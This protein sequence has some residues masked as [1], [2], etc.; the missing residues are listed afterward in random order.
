VVR[1]EAGDTIIRHPAQ[2]FR[3][4]KFNN[5]FQFTAG[6]AFRLGDFPDAGTPSGGQRNLHRYWWNP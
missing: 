3:S 5:N 4:A 1:L 6:V 2:F